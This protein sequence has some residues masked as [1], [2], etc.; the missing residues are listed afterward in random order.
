MLFSMLE[1]ENSTLLIVSRSSFLRMDPSEIVNMLSKKVNKSTWLDVS[2]HG[3]K[4]G[5]RQSWIA[6]SFY[7]RYE[8]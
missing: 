5:Q 4:D 1:S 2:T 6:H 3:A 8:F 7:D